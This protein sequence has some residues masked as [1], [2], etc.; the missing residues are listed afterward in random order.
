M[1]YDARQIADWFIGRAAQDGR[2][3]SIMH[4]LK[5]VYISH[6]WHLEMRNAPLISN[7]I[8]AWQ[9]GPVIP[10]VY[11]AFRSQGVDVKN[12]LQFQ[13]SELAVK[14]S[15]L[16]DEIYNIYG[17]ISAFRLSEITHEVGGPWDLATKMGGNY[18]P[19]LDEL[20]KSHYQK[21]RLLAGQA[22]NVG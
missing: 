1:A 6:G 21:K 10:D 17:K 3:L 4:L 8:E 22:A 9:Y 7:G 19:I 5:L 15:K 14:D 12:S 18:A 20:I 16:L 2:V 13:G 11:H